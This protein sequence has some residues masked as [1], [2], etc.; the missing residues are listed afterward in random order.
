MCPSLCGGAQPSEDPVLCS[1][2]LAMPRD[3]VLCA[4]Q[5]RRGCSRQEIDAYIIQARERSYETMVRF[6]KRGLNMAA[7][8]AVQAAT[9]VP[10]TGAGS[11]ASLK[12]LHPQGTREKTPT[13]AWVAGEGVSGCR[14]LP[15]GV[16]SPWPEIRVPR[17]FGVC[18]VGLNSVLSVSSAEPGRAGGAA[19]QLQH[20]G[21]ALH[22]R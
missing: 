6:G 20:A 8:A 10:G 9:K 19:P 5:R 11:S 16:A 17:R 21:P 7:T 12:M 1:T 13:L 3:V 15:G 4:A 22:P 14:A 18:A 2:G